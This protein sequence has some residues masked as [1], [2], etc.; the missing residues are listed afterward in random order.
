MYTVKLYNNIA[1]KGL[2]QF[3]EAFEV[4]EHLGE[5]RKSVV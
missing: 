1:Q 3:T 5:D 4:G 2:D